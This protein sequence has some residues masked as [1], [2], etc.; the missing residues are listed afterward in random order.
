V[1]GL[2]AKLRAQEAGVGVGFLP[3]WIAQPA[4]DQGRLVPLKVAAPKPRLQLSVAWR[5]QGMGPAGHWF[6][7]RLQQMTLG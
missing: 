5:P 7:E 2:Q 3:S 4:I 1:A 6:V